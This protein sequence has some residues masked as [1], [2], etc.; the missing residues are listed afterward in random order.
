[1]SD[2]LLSLVIFTPLL[3]A[4]LVWVLWERHRRPVLLW[5][6]PAA[7]AAWANIHGTFPLG[8]LLIALEA[9]VIVR[10]LVGEACRRATVIPRRT[11]RTDAAFDVGR[12]SIAIVHAPR[13]ITS[14]P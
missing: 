13:L 1:M 5:S 3:F 12:I 14:R 8:L 10:S 4:A 2:S 6:I 7:L 9:T 11:N